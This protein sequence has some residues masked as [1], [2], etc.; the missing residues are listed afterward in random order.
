M[1]EFAAVPKAHCAL[2][3]LVKLPFSPQCTGLCSVLQKQS[4]G[5]VAVGCVA[6]TAALHDTPSE[7]LEFPAQQ[8]RRSTEANWCDTGQYAGK[9][10]RISSHLVLVRLVSVIAGAALKR[11]HLSCSKTPG[12]PR[13]LAG[14]KKTNLHEGPPITVACSMHNARHFDSVRPGM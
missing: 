9:V 3:A 12:S 5:T 1:H 14:E 8:L 6:H 10:H 11:T 13:P 2:Q 4:A 7:Q